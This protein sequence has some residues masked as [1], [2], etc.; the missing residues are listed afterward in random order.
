MRF[1]NTSA[2]V[3]ALALS[4]SCS[5]LKATILADTNRD[6]KVDVKGDTD[7]KGKAEWTSERGALILANIGDTDR[8]CSKKLPDNDSASEVNEAFLD[9]CNDATGNVQRNAKYLAPLRTLPIAKLSYSAKGSIHVTDD[10]AAE[11]IRVFVKEGN[12][13]TYVAANHTF[14]AQEL[15][16][17]LELGVDARDVRRP[18]WDGKA[19]VH[20]T[21]QDGAQKAEDSV[22]LR[23][24][25]VMTHHHLQLAERVFSTDSDYTGAQTTFVSDLKENVAA[26][27]ID[28]PV[29]LFSNGDIWIQD[30]FEP[31]YTSIPGPDGPIVLRVMIRSAQA[32]RFSG[33]DIF[34][35]L[36]N[37]KVGAVQHPGDGDT[38]DSAGNL[39][40]VPPYTL[41]GKSYPAGRIIQG[42]WDGR[43]PLIHEFL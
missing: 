41:N 23:V 37:D 35:Q 27:G 36:R 22:A 28:E 9:K 20:F 1:F 43:K 38:L 42:Q 2:A 29:F 39:E 30:F 33:R 11:N 40:T 21:V 10:A 24:A 3:L 19:Q 31:G 8:R 16:D 25:P 17:G 14:T 32:G 7:I 34:R 13:W 12:D 4:N 26:A 5:A 18:T 6:G 15:Q